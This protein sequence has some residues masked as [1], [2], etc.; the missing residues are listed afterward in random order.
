VSRESVHIY[1]LQRFASVRVFAQNG[2]LA[3]HKPLLLL[4]ALS[5]LKNEKAV[6]IT[7]NEAEV[8]VN[9]L[10]Q[11]YG[12]F[13]TKT[14]VAYPYNRLA[15]DKSKVWWVE[16]HKR[17]ASGNLYIT[18]ARD[19]HLQA[20]FLDDIL[21]AFE[22]SPKLID[23]VAINIL[24]RNF[25]PSLHA[26]ILEAVELFLGQG[27]LES[28]ERQKRDPKFR[29]IILAAYYEQCAICHYDLKMNG[30]SVALEAAHIKMHAAGG[31]DMVTN[32]LAL[33]STHHK[34]FDLG[35]V[36]LDG[37]LNIRVSERVVGD[38]GRRLTDEFHGK[39]IAMPRQDSMSP[40]REFTE[41]HNDQIFK[42]VVAE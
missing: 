24:E 20:G 12:P 4:Y 38:W 42:G 37:Q 23:L 1:I 30:M 3:P 29:N 7:F 32:G 11:T 16:D 14:T 27:E 35:A 17:D 15:N 6:R 34:L 2:K 5:R 31:P 19:K 41:W 36:T 18:E 25:P 28:I 33:C 13:N 26:D 10:L 9:P 39:P 21:K 8:A 22:Q 40:E